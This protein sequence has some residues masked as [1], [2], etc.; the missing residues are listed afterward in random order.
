MPKHPFFVS[1]VCLAL[2]L[3][4]VFWL[5]AFCGFLRCLR[6]RLRGLLVY[7]W[8]LCRLLAVFN[9]RLLRLLSRRDS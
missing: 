5:F 8:R 2:R 4:T 3:L 1:G 7:D 9:G 6:C